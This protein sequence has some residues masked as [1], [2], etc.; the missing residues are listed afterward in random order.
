VA[1]F[2]A[3]LDACILYPFSLRDLFMRLALSEMFRAKWTEDIHDEWMRNVLS[4]H[5]HL[6]QRL[7]RTR[8]LMDTHVRDCLVTN[9]QGLIPALTL[10]DPDDCH[11]L[12]A[13]IVGRADVIVTFNLKDFPNSVLHPY[14]IEA[15]H[16]D[17]FIEHLLD[18]NKPKVCA[19]V[20]EARLALKNPPKTPDEYLAILEKQ[21]LFK[22]VRI[23][24]ECPDLL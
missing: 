7:Q 21:N 11:V 10:P 18:L 17:V 3:L 23:L 14:D 5:P 16:P 4:E 24:R 15:Q 9:Y 13:A 19:A 22:T 8:E 1:S 20:Q 6:T 2:T 12:A